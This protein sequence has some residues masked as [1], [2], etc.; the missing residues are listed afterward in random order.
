M[1]GFRT[2]RDS[3]GEVQVPAEAYY[4]AQTQRAVENFQISGNTLPPSLIHAMGKTAPL[5]R[6]W[7]L[8]AFSALVFNT[9]A[10]DR[11]A[12]MTSL[13][14]AV[15]MGLQIAVLGVGVVLVIN[16]QLTPP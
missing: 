2:E 15:R 6:R 12:L 4:G 3:M 5:I 16:S 1:S 9:L 7:Q 14:K 11:V 13:A 8:K 10:T